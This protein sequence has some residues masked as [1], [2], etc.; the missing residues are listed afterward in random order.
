MEWAGLSKFFC[1]V[2]I[3]GVLIFPR[4]LEALC[5]FVASCFDHHI[6]WRQSSWLFKNNKSNITLNLKEMKFPY[7]MKDSALPAAGTH[8]VYMLVSQTHTIW[9]FPL[10]PAMLASLLSWASSWRRTDRQMLTPLCRYFCI[11]VTATALIQRNGF[12]QLVLGSSKWM[13][14]VY[15]TSLVGSPVY[16]KLVCLPYLL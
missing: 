7:R 13:S 2:L 10:I 16:P 9:E 15:C 6:K 14:L 5:L 8:L 11:Q 3:L 12:V 1:R 4:V